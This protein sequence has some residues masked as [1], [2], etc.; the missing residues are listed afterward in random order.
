ML[1]LLGTFA[2][3]NGRAWKRYD[4]LVVKA[5]RGQGLTTDPDVRSESVYL[6]QAGQL[7][8]KEL[9][10]KCFWVDTN[11]AGAGNV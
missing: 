1:A 11:A 10:A 6:T 2:F 4:F 5:L 8:V 7:K 3:E 9:A